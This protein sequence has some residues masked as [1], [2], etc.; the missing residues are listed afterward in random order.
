VIFII[1]GMIQSLRKYEMNYPKKGNNPLFFVG[2]RG[3][4]YH[5]QFFVFFGEGR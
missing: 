2:C 1:L 3:V 5:A 4:I